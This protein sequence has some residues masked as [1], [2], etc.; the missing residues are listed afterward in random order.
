[1]A[2]ERL[3][4]GGILTFKSDQAVQGLNQASQATGK[5]RDAQGRYIRGAAQAEQAT[6]K[7]GTSAARAARSTTGA[8]QKMG[9]AAMSAARSVQMLA[10]ATLPLTAAVGLGTAKAADFEQQMSTVKSITGATGEEMALLTSTAKQFGATTSFSATQ[11]AQGLEEL[12]RAGFKTKDAVAALGGVLNAAAADNIPLATSATIVANT[13]N[14]MGLK[15]SQ[16][17]RVADVLAKTSASA[18][19]DIIGLGEALKFA[20]PVADTLGVKLPEVSAALGSLANAGLKGTMG[21]NALKNALLKLAK[22]T[23]AGQKEMA[24]LGIEIHK[25]AEGNLDLGAT[26]K[27]VAAGLATESDKVKR[28]A[29]LAEILGL[30]GAGA[31]TAMDKAFSGGK[32]GPL[33]DELNHQ[34]TEGGAAA[35]MAATRL[36]NFKGTVTLLQS[37]LEGFSIETMGQFLSGGKGGLKAVV[38]VVSDVVQALQLLNGNVDE[39]DERWKKLSPTVIAVAKGINEGIGAIIDGL[40]VLKQAFKSAIRSITGGAST[41]LI[42]SIAKWATIIMTVAAVVMPI[43]GT[44][45]TAA[46]LIVSQWA[47]LSTIGTAVGAALSAAFWPVVLVVGALAIAFLAVQEDGEST[48]QTLLRVFGLVKSAIM[49]VVDNAIMPLINSFLDGIMP[50]VRSTQAVVGVFIDRAT[51]LFRDLFSDV[52]DIANKFA[53]LFQLAFRLIGMFLGFLFKQFSTVFN[54]VLMVISPVLEILQDVAQFIVGSLI[55]ALVGLAKVM[56][57]VGD[58]LPGNLVPPELREFV[59]TG[60]HFKS[61]VDVPKGGPKIV[62]AGRDPDELMKEIDL[63]GGVEKGLAQGKGAGVSTPKLEAEVKLEDNRCL[64]VTSETKIDGREAAIAVGKAKLDLS[65]RA[66]F[67]AQ[68]WQRRFVLEQGAVPSGTRGGGL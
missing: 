60:F 22:P 24:R 63:V 44:L 25:T 58:S 14:S 20:A 39:T 41:E 7:V 51:K 65:E 57:S 35:D 53:P 64:N 4:L 34:F 42:Q 18:A 27:S 59:K 29:A 19:T 56:V 8:F 66:G 61:T 2:L 46:V 10:V 1:M 3:G 12:G 55:N 33:L 67:A 5:L 26:F 47:T 40:S 68:P 43:L 50:A 32:F 9:G 52:Q 54:G 6:N 17:S 30:R 36:D 38:A 45:A 62:K 21:G 16:A 13:V 15:A 49:F 23:S 37:A 31:A 11:S 48:G 28:T